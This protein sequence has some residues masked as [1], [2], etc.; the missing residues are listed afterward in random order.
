MI[1]TTMSIINLALAG[2]TILSL[3]RAW[4]LCQRYGRKPPALIL[5]LS[6]C[7]LFVSLQLMDLLGLI[8]PG[9]LKSGWHGFDMLAL[10][11]MWSTVHRLSKK[12]ANLT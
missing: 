8:E 9:R 2:L 6:A 7:V 3:W 10:A 12:R 4:D 1:M 5:P 11:A